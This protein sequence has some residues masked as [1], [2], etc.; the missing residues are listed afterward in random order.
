MPLSRRA[1]LTH[2]ATLAAAGALPSGILA[3]PRFT[4]DPFT[5]GVASGYPQP[6]GCVL[7]TRLAPKPIAGG[8]MPAR[9]VEV[10][11]EIAADEAFRKI[12]RQGKTRAAP[13][14]AHSVHV[15]VSDLEPARWYWYRFHS[16]G[17][18]SPVGR[19]R[20]APAAGTTLNRLRF[21]FA[22]CQQFE[23]G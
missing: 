20:T 3:K 8:G 6:D 11:W 1:F 10:G 23:Q 12:V 16:G 5:L 21:A 22:S 19:T 4:D 14:W 15:E 9:A 17:A 13:Q 2:A 18:V 7:W